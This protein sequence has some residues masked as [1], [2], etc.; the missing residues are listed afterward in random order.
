MSPKQTTAYR[1]VD[2]LFTLNSL[3]SFIQ[4]T[5]NFFIKS[6]LLLKICPTT[7]LSHPTNLGSTV[8][9]ARLLCN[10]EVVIWLDEQPAVDD[11]TSYGAS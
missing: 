9:L 4:C 3:F 6:N 8:S 5:L 7:I 1:S 11:G 2:D 10:D